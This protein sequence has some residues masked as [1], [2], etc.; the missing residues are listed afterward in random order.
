MGL[1][2][3]SAGLA[4]IAAMVPLIVADARA[5]A[6]KDPVL[7]K[8]AADCENR[9]A[10]AL[11]AAIETEPQ[12]FRQQWFLARGDDGLVGLTHSVL[13]PVP[14]IYAGEFGPPGLLMED[15]CLAP[16]ATPGTARALLRAAETDLRVAGAQAL[17]ASSVPDGAWEPV[18][19]T[20]G[21]APLARYFARTDL[22]ARRKIEAIRPATETDMDEIVRLSAEHRRILHDL[23][24][25][26]KPHRGADA[27][28]GAW[29]RKCLTLGDRD[30]LV[31]G[32]AA[33]T[34]YAIAQPAS[35][36]HFPAAHE[37]GATGVIDDFRHSGLRN[38][39]RL[40][41]TGAAALLEAAEAALKARGH[42]AALVVCPAAW[43]SK[44]ALLESAGYRN[45]IT[46][47]KKERLVPDPGS[48]RA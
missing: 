12:S 8:L 30:M 33:V 20:H 9:V 14:P 24:S 22:R 43:T 16:H 5:R 44:A 47:L 25:F 15:C 2:I 10:D 28:F 37:I 19:V 4:D 26:W 46:W 41:E 13:L 48:S 45:A 34:G 1:T 39:G 18:Y 32:G 7:W 27:R 17:L 3:G 23:D 29:M 21:Y 38:P 42:G 36:L 11:H 31:S 35:R 6:A 40:Q